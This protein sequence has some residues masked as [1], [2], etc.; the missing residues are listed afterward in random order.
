MVLLGSTGGVLWDS[1]AGTRF[2]SSDWQRVGETA[3]HKV[4]GEH[5]RN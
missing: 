1:R 2:D 4:V 3:C 5:I